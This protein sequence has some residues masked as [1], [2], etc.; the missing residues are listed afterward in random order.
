MENDLQSPR[1]GPTSSWGGCLPFGHYVQVYEDDASYL[2]SLEAFAAT[3][4]AADDAVVVIATEGHL[5]ELGAR[6]AARGVDVELAMREDRLIFAPARRTLDDLLKDDFPDEDRF[7]YVIG[8]LLA[9]ARRS[10][11]NVRAFGEMVALL[12]QEG[13]AAATVRLEFLWNRLLQTERFP[14]FCAY[15]RSAFAKSGPTCMDELC[16]MHT[17]VV[18]AALT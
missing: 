4:L 17:A 15:P 2:L 8:D 5:A 14:L 1:L 13:N 12:W 9:R 10:G 7:T 18:P 16:A 3:G 11:R 6:L